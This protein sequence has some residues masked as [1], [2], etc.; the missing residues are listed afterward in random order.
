MSMFPPTQSERQN[1]ATNSILDIPDDADVDVAS[2]LQE[3]QVMEVL[4]KLDEELVGLNSVKTRIRE[5]AAALLDRDFSGFERE[6]RIAFAAAL[7]V[8][9]VAPP[10]P[11]VVRRSSRRC[12]PVRSRIVRDA[13]REASSLCIA[14]GDAVL[15][16]VAHQF[17]G[18]PP[19]ANR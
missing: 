3:S 15:D 9:F 2:V 19:N 5:I 13:H 14:H 17:G 7:V 10:A 16:T 11:L 4:Q 1:G 12:T 18:S 8:F 6:K